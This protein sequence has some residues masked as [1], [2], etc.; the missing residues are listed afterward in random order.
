MD[1]QPI[2]DIV[3]RRYAQVHGAVPN[4]DFP[5]FH[6]HARNNVVGAALGYRR[7]DSGALFLEAYLDRPVEAELNDALGR[8]FE[9]C[10]I[11]EIG[12]MAAE[13]APAMIAL[14]A[15]AANDLGGRAEIAVAVLTAQLRSM[16]RRLG[17]TIHE[18]VPAAAE[19]LGASA[20]SWGSYYA[21]DPVVCAG[22]IA[23]GQERLARFATRH[24]RACA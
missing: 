7:A 19:R 17:L 10:D 23:E 15:D 6:S 8:S 3:S 12:N 21:Q 22:L 2:F 1:R 20:D 9:R 5:A 18:L 24:G 4:L 13:T 16:F 11:I 14:W